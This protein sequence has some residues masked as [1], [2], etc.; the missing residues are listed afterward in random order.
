MAVTSDIPGK[1]DAAAAIEA[2]GA[3]LWRWELKERQIFLSESAGRLLAARDNSMPQEQ[4]LALIDI[5]DREPVRR[6]LEENLYQGKTYD[7]AFRLLDGI[8]W[9]RMRGRARPESDHADGILLD[10]GERRG[11]L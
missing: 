8:R 9:C 1:D 4:F 2:A 5:H 6:A 3:G 7:V 10:I 11:E